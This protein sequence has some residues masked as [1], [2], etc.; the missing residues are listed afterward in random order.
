MNAGVEPQPNFVVATP[1]RSPCDPNAQALARHQLLRFVALGTRR[2]IA[3]VPMDRTHLN[4]WFGLFTYATARTFSAS[5][6]E[7]MRLRL[8]GAFDHWVKMQLQPGDHI[9]SSYGYANASFRWVR[10]HGGRTFLDGGSSHPDNYWSILE[11][12]HR[13]WKSP[14]PPMP[15]HHYRRAL[16]MMPHVDYVLSPSSFV[17]NSF[18]TRG[19]RPEQILRNVYP[20]DLS[21][22][23]PAATPRPA[24]RPLSIISTGML[25][26]RKGTPYLL[27]A[28]RL[29]LRRFPTARLLLTSDFH[30]NVRALLRENADLPIDWS[31]SLPHA[32]L[33]ERLRRADIF[34]L[35]SLEDGFARTVTEALAC[36][37]PAV[38]TPNTGASDLVRPG[39][40]GAIVPIC[41]GAA[42][43]EAILELADAVLTRREPAQCLIDPATLSFAHFEREFLAQLRERNL[44]PPAAEDPRPRA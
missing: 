11:E 39:V 20:L 13:R 26:L 16:E 25:S 8:H 4:P 7:S 3:G 41:D 14:Q 22:F 10:E 34:V 33:A 9:I 18:L 21:C 23:S 24:G 1:G 42:I 17:S 38:V 32:Q 2:G 19:F 31:P 28:F 15:R 29:V 37:L 12:E 36:G 35:P 30:D 44:I 27:E 43:A 6:A 5:R 40:N